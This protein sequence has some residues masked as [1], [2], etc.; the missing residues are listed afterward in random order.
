MLPDLGQLKIGAINERDDDDGPVRPAARTEAIGIPASGSRD[1][2]MCLYMCA[3]NTPAAMN[4]VVERCQDAMTGSSGFDR[5]SKVLIIRAVPKYNTKWLKD[6]R[7]E[8]II[9]TFADNH[10]SVTL[11]DVDLRWYGTAAHYDS[12]RTLY[13]SERVSAKA[14]GWREEL[15]LPPPDAGVLDTVINEKMRDLVNDLVKTEV[16]STEQIALLN[17]LYEMQNHI[18]DGFTSRTW[19]EWAY[20]RIR[21]H[22]G[23]DKKW[24]DSDFNNMSVLSNVIGLG[25]AKAREA[26]EKLVTVVNEGGAKRTTFD[27]QMHRMRWITKYILE[28]PQPAWYYSLDLLVYLNACE[29]GDGPLSMKSKT[30]VLDSAQIR[31]DTCTRLQNLVEAI[32]NEKHKNIPANL[33]LPDVV[34]MD[35]EVDD[36][37]VVF[38]LMLLRDLLYNK[39]QGLWE[40]TTNIMAVDAMMPFPERGPADGERLF[41]V[42]S[43][44]RRWQAGRTCGHAVFKAHKDAESGNLDKVQKALSE[45]G[46]YNR[47]KFERNLSEMVKLAQGRL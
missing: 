42:Y 46:Q 37:N 36:F 47:V 13:S 15:A 16:L 35:C 21:D 9:K 8:D 40:K 5:Y 34:V 33:I 32:V 7:A 1:D 31:S 43:A 39:R 30:V 45:D 6:K 27:D 44:M 24:E 20:S 26:V 11:H 38:F 23:A 14:N 28:Q 2:T 10:E 17:D 22:R 18:R 3:Q 29:L 25:V 4:L 12:L 41:D 19:K